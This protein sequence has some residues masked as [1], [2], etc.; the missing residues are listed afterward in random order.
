MLAASIVKDMVPRKWKRVLRERFLP[1][2]VKHL[3]G[4]RQIAL[5]DDEAAVTCVLRNGEYYLDSFVEHYSRMGFRHIFIL[6]NGSTDR[7]VECAR[8][9]KNVTVYESTL[10]IEAYQAVFKKRL[11]EMSAPKGWC[12]DVDM[13]EYFDY[14]FSH[15]VSLSKFLKY[16]NRGGY[17][18][19]LAQMLDMFS[20]MPVAALA[21]KRPE[22]N[23]KEVYRYYDLSHICKV[24]YRT[25][26]MTRAHAP[27][28]KYSS[29]ST[30]LYFGGIRKALFGTNCLLTKHSLFRTGKGL[31]LFP[32]VHFVNNARVADVSCV[33]YHYKLVS[34]AY[35]TALQNKTAFTGTSKGYSDLMG[36]IEKRPE[37]RIKTETTVEFHDLSELLAKDFLF[38]SKDYQ[39]YCTETGI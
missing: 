17:T 16:L 38:T 18:A 37:Y 34:N 13:D 5:A 2:Y 31:E 20:D 30:C 32:H 33:L 7:T 4:P 14:P 3:F 26:E 28:N 36:L 12:L 11:A 25:A 35:E 1:L 15:V 8:R 27:R 23:V 21:H 10:P 29:A 6:D 22:E 39:R 9:H 19:V 24:D